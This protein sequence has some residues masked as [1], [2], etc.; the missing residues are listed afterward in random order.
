MSLLLAI[1]IV[2]LGLLSMY[3]YWSIHAVTHNYITVC[4]YVRHDFKA[5]SNSPK[6]YCACAEHKRQHSNESKD[7]LTTDHLQ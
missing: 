6:Y 2:I 1:A 3:F 7:H 4:M 5:S